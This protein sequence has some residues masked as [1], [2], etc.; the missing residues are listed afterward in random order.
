VYLVSHPEGVKHVLQD[1]RH[2]YRKSARVERIKPVFGEGLTTS[3]G[4]LWRRQRRLMQP[5]FQHQEVAALAP[6]ITGA[7]GSMLERWQAIAERGQPLDVASEMMSLMRGII[8]RSLFGNDVPE[9]GEALG[10][11]LTVAFDH[12]NHRVWALIALPEY[13]PTPRNRRFQ[14]ALRTARTLVDRIIAERRREGTDRADLLSMLMR[15]RD[16]TTGEGM[17]AVQLRDEVMTLFVAGHTTTA[18]AL[19]WTWYLLS[20]APGVEPQLRRELRAVPR[21]STRSASVRS[22]RPA[23]HPTPTSRSVGGRACASAEA[24]P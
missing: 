19:A 15:A 12:L 18:T 4:D 9:E 14:R 2:N 22:A 23:A 10:Q 17:S 21:G 1:D 7:T 5:A 16:G 6:L 20:R 13:V 11:A 24:S 8:G 3:E